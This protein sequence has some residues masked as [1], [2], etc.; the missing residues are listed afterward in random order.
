[1]GCGS[2]Y[3][4]T[5]FLGAASDEVLG[6]DSHEPSIAYATE[7]FSRPGLEFACR[8]AASVADGAERFDVVVLADVLEHLDD[9][10]ALLQRSRSVLSPGGMLLITVPNGYGPFEIESAISRVPVIGAALL[11]ATDYLV[12]AL[13][14]FGPLRGAWT[15]TL[16]AVPSE[17]PYNAESG[18]VQFFTL[19]SLRRLVEQ[20][21]CRVTQRTNLSFLSGPFTNYLFA[22]SQSF[23]RWN[24]EVSGLLPPALASGWFL[25]CEMA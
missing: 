8:T 25:K 22:P 20:A 2:G 3:A 16:S 11:K 14:K 15:N 7:H 13:N 6:I 17:L 10:A 12:A 19:K 24:V 9:P 23:C 4:V 1:V 18:H 21:G 5:R